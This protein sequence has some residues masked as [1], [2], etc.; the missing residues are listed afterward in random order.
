MARKET[1]VIVLSWFLIAA[2]LVASATASG[3]LG[4]IDH[5]V[6]HQ[7]CRCCLFDWGPPLIKCVKACCGHGCKCT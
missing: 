2:F 1:L 6:Q 7:A 5:V 3:R 4:T